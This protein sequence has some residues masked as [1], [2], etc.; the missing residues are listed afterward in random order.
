M[1]YLLLQTYPY[2]N[3]CIVNVIW[4][5]YFVG[6][7]NSFTRWFHE[8]FPVHQGNDGIV[9]HEVPMPI[10]VLVV[11]AVSAI[12]NLLLIGI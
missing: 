5:L 9:L 6:G 4:D 10:V 8:Q 1:N 11:T 7:S 12:Y 2:R 3:I